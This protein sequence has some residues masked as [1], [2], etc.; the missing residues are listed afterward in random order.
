MYPLIAVLTIMTAISTANASPQPGDVF[1][2]RVWKGPY[3]N[4]SGW[5][6]VTD[7]DA[8]HA[9]AAE[10]LPN[11][12]NST[13]L[14]D[15]EDA[16]RAELYI[17]QW[18]GHAG[19]SAKRLRLNGNDWIDI[20]EPAAIPGDA[21]DGREFPECYQ[22]F[23]YPS[24]P[25]P[26]DQLIEGENSFEFTC[27]RQICFNFGWGQW[28]VYA[29]T[30]RIYYDPSS[31][32]ATGRIVSPT[33]GTTFAD[34]LHILLEG[35]DDIEQVDFIGLYEEYDY[36]GNGIY[37]QWH[38]N[39][40]YGEI[41]RHLG[42]AT[43]PPYAITWN[44]EWVP[45]QDEPIQIVA[46]VKHAD[47]TYYMTEAVDNIHLERT[48]R[49]VKL[50]K[51]FDV[52]GG[53]QTRAQKRHR[54]K[55]FVSHDLSRATAAQMILTTWSGGHAD[56]IG[57]NDSAVVKKVGSYHTYSFDE[58]D[59]PLGLIRPGTNV[60]FTYART[61]HHGIEVLWPGIALKVEYA[62]KI[63]T[64][65]ETKVREEPIYADGLSDKWQ[66]EEL[67]PRLFYETRVDLAAD[68]Q[69][70]QGQNALGLES[71]ERFWELKLI[72]TVPVDISRHRALRF[73]FLPHSV[74]L[75]DPG[76]FNISG[77]FKLNVNEQRTIT[78]MSPKISFVDIQSPTWQ[79]VE[80]PLD[81]LG[82]RFPYLES[83]RFY[84]EF[85]G[86]FYLDDLRLLPSEENTAVL[87]SDVQPLSSGTRLLPNFP[88]PF[89]GQTTIRFELPQ[90][91]NIDLGIYNLAGQ[92]LLT[93]TRGQYPSG[94]HT[95][96][97]DG[98][99]ANGRSLS[100]GVYFYRLESE[101][102]ST[103]RRLLLLQ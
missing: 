16:V 60:F 1:R 101:S 90:T 38:Y 18:G 82:L 103:S 13:T 98:R 17:E 32:H 45:D 81:T 94:T 72:P 65:S 46:R 6:R 61:T 25:L 69:A 48:D 78:L 91:E 99:G 77:W 62:G 80:I 68:A 27:D 43:E 83:L 74:E 9:G 53:W 34:S 76:S 92:H 14:D 30:F 21:G 84:G 24:V 11:P 37:R 79:T 50:Y 4:A 88:N 86:R 102:R 44:A 10:F 20:P 51:P 70:F 89:N 100:S 85:T 35:D 47:G 29:A 75:P 64:E 31:P 57:I 28:G 40:R 12:V 55:V 39:Y 67:P 63:D 96:Q 93:L 59:L 71:P 41:K 95:L 58:I 3:L 15:L 49:S 73:A 42:T 97:W 26:L 66:V 7:P 56:S 33:S 19:T 54:C 87:T 52:P 36:E 2:E 23:T 5:Q 8:T 22:Y